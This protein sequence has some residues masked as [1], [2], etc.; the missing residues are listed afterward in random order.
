[1]TTTVFDVTLTR[2]QRAALAYL[3]AHGHVWPAGRGRHA[4]GNDT[5]W[6]ARTLQALVDAGVAAWAGSVYETPYAH[7][8]MP[9]VVP[10]DTDPCQHSGTRVHQ[11]DSTGRCRWCRHVTTLTDARR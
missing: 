10:I 4:L 3:R 2:T 6:E 8:V 7:G 5:P 9:H 1:M 11:P